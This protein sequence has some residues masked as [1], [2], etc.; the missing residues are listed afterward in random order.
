MYEGK[1]VIDREALSERIMKDGR[2]LKTIADTAGV[3]YRELKNMLTEGTGY[4]RS[5]EKVR[6]VLRPKMRFST[7]SPDELQ[8]GYVAKDNALTEQIPKHQE[9]I[10]S[11]FGDDIKR[12]IELSDKLVALCKEYSFMSV[13]RAVYEFQDNILDYLDDTGFDLLELIDESL[14]RYPEID[15]SVLEKGDN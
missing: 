6:K 4:P 1:R 3:S 2:L 5:I 13:I 11:L 15:I 9:S 8:P 14:K 10:I 7:I 12:D